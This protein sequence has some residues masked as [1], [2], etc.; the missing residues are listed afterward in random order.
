MF[1]MSQDRKTVIESTGKVFSVMNDNIHKGKAR[2]IVEDEL[3]VGGVFTI[4]RYHTVNRAE[5]VLGTLFENYKINAPTFIFPEE[6]VVK[7][8]GSD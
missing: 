5:A 1:V 8:L 4:A 6:R 3:V 2:I 7:E